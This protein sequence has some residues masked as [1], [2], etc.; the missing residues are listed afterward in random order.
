MRIYIE[1]QKLFKGLQPGFTKQQIGEVVV[2]NEAYKKMHPGQN[3]AP[4]QDDH[5][6]ALLKLV[7]H[8]F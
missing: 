3:H 8:Y 4:L 6:L 7:S 1:N 5:S 2:L